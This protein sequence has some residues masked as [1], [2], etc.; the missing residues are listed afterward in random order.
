[1][2]PIISD[3]VKDIF[4]NRILNCWLR[5]HNN[6][7]CFHSSL[8][9]TTFIKSLKIRAITMAKYIKKLPCI[10]QNL[11]ASATKS[12]WKIKSKIISVSSI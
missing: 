6:L 5:H 2:T 8:K 12:K 1:M 3:M 4:S 10:K 9:L 7:F 11:D